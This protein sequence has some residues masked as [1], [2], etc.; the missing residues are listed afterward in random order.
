[1]QYVCFIISRLKNQTVAFIVLPR[2]F[3]VYSMITVGGLGKTDSVL[4]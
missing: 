2:S 4:Q 1:M 3:G